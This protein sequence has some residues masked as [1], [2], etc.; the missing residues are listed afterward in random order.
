MSVRWQHFID[1]ADTKQKPA[2]VTRLSSRRSSAAD[3][4]SVKRDYAV[5]CGAVPCGAVPCGN[6]M[7]YCSVT[8]EAEVVSSSAA[9]SQVAAITSRLNMED[10]VTTT[11]TESDDEPNT[12]NA[13]GHA[14]PISRARVEMAYKKRKEKAVTISENVEIAELPPSSA[15]E[16]EYS[17]EVEGE[18]GN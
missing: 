18:G 17:T 16:S 5:P 15:S 7:P 4:Q 11:E 2:N 13:F 14:A 3:R 9:R 8:D 6:V 1:H 12:L 10:E